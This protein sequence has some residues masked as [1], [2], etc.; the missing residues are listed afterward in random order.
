M[1]ETL[2]NIDIIGNPGNR[3]GRETLDD[4]DVIGNP[5]GKGPV[6]GERLES[7]DVI[8]QIRKRSQPKHLRYPLELSSASSPFKNVVRFTVYQQVRSSGN[9]PGATPYFREVPEQYLN[10]GRTFPVTPMAFGSAFV[11]RSS[12]FNNVS[13]GPLKVPSVGTIYEDLIGIGYYGAEFLTNGETPNF[14]KRTL[15]LQSTITLYMPETILNQDTH[16]YQNISINA[17]AGR[18]GLYT[19]GNPIPLGGTGSPLGRTEMLFELAGRAGIFGSRAAEAGLA[20]LG[21]ALN[22]MLEM[23]YGGSQ[24]RRFNFQFRF[25]PRNKQEAEEVLKIIKTFRFHSYSSNAGAPDDPMSVDTGTR[26]L[27][28]PDHFELQFMRIRNGRLEEN[29]AMP[30]VTT[31]MLAS[32][33]TNYAAM[34][35]SFA[36]FKDG[37]PISI[38]LDLEFVENAIL[39]QNDIKKGY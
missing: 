11:T 37:T 27:I 30:R 28:P 14:G 8:G 24:Q 31:C 10:G 1:T 34:L 16:D 36:T 32:V 35:D 2:D 33:N 7:V 26:Y 29:L 6:D 19:A 25:S 20:G 21:Y 12:L 23:I 38:S 4:I 15:K 39:T 18:A 3:R 17:A 9:G 5:G 13:I 22:P